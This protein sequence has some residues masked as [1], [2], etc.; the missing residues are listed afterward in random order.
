MFLF[1]LIFAIK[2]VTENNAMHIPLQFNALQKH[3]VSVIVVVIFLNNNK[4]F[5]LVVQYDIDIDIDIGWLLSNEQVINDIF[6]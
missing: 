3:L 2:N 6:R 1:F 4:F 5:K